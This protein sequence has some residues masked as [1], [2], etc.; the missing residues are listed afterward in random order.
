[1]ANIFNW[2]FQFPEPIPS[3]GSEALLDQVCPH[4]LSQ[5]HVTYAGHK[6]VIHMPDIH[7]LLGAVLDFLWWIVYI[8]PGNGC[9]NLPCWEPRTWQRRRARTGAAPWGRSS[10][11]Q[12]SNSYGNGGNRADPAVQNCPSK[13]T[14]GKDSFVQ[15]I[16]LVTFTSSPRQ[17]ANVD[18]TKIN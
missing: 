9:I 5:M 17:F 11:T 2:S 1:M 16:S 6:C 14:R 15:C 10:W 7:R 4:L 12:T 18:I 13:K 8:Q 3:R